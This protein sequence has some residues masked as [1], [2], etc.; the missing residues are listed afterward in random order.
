VEAAAER[1][2]AIGGRYKSFCSILEK[3]LDQQPIQQPPSP[4][5][6]TPPHGNIRGAQYF[7]SN[8]TPEVQ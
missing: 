3:G 7:N 5:R 2:L 4:P 1:T 6:S 8:A